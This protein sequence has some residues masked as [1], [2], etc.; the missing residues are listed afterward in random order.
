MAN[1]RV[2]EETGEF[3]SIAN[4]SNEGV[5]G[6]V[7]KLSAQRKRHRRS[8]RLNVGTVKQTKLRIKGT[9]ISNEQEIAL[10]PARLRESIALAVT[11]LF[12][13]HGDNVRFKWDLLGYDQKTNVGELRI[14]TSD[15]VG[16]RA[17][18]ASL[19][20]EHGR[21]QIVKE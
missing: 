20:V 5:E 18:L 11:S 6:D 10:G 1:K 4:Y 9:V 12:G 8:R 13:E 3:I 2:V 21:L 14:T 19:C 15:L 17:A 16:F 7:E